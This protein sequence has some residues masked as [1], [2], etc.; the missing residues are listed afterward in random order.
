MALIVAVTCSKM[1]RGGF[2]S[3]HVFGVDVHGIDELLHPGNVPV[4]TGLKQL[5]KGSARSAAAR[6]PSAGVRGGDG[7]GPAALGGGRG[8]S[9]A[10]GAA[11]AAAAAGGKSQNWRDGGGG[12]CCGGGRVRGFLPLSRLFQRSSGGKRGIV[13]GGRRRDRR[14]AAGERRSAG[15]RGLQARLLQVRLLLRGATR[16]RHFHN[17][18]TSELP[19]LDVSLPLRDVTPKLGNY[20]S[21]K[22]NKYVCF[23]FHKQVY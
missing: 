16:R 12:G 21:Y 2:A 9:G 22:L 14:T 17:T 23:S 6:V 8:A 20:K 11:A 5:P 4:P 3:C 1:Q 15:R 7:A 10:A 19:V 18:T 13:G